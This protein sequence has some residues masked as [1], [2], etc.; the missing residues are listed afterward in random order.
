M[1]STIMLQCA[2]CGFNLRPSRC[3]PG[4]S[5]RDCSLTA[6]EAGTRVQLQELV[7]TMLDTALT[8]TVGRVDGFP[9]FRILRSHPIS[10]IRAQS[11]PHYKMGLGRGKYG[12]VGEG[13]VEWGGGPSCTVALP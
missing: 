1:H 9:S 13:L 3:L 10:F 12:R 7:L 6:A 4:Y 5:G 8:S 11:I 2:V